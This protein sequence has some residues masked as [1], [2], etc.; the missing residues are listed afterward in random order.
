MRFQDA[1]DDARAVVYAGIQADPL[2]ARAADL[3]ADASPGS[4]PHRPGRDERRDERR[5]GVA[6]DVPRL[7]ADAADR[8]RRSRPIRGDPRACRWT[9]RAGA[10]R[11][12]AS[13]AARSSRR[14]RPGCW[15]VASCRPPSIASAGSC[16]MACAPRSTRTTSPSSCRSGPRGTT[17]SGARAGSAPD[18]LLQLDAARGH[19]E[20]EG[21]R[22]LVALVV[23]DARRSC[24]IRL[25]RQTAPL[26]GVRLVTIETL[27]A[28]GRAKVASTP[29]ERAP[30]NRPTATRATLP[31][32]V[33]RIHSGRAGAHVRAPAV[34]AGRRVGALG[35]A[36]LRPCLVRRARAR[37]ARPRSRARRFWPIPLGTSLEVTTSVA[38]HR[39]GLGP[40]ASASSASRAATDGGLVAWVHTDWLLIDARGR[41]TRVPAIFGTTFPAPLS[42][43]TLGRVAIPAPP[44]SAARQRF[45]VRPHELDPMDHVNNAVYVDWLEETVIAAGPDGARRP[46][47]GPAALPARGRGRR[48][49][50]W[51]SR[52]RHGATERGWAHR[53]A[54]DGTDVFRA[55]LDDL[56]CPGVLGC[57]GSPAAR[58]SPKSSAAQRRPGSGTIGLPGQDVHLSTPRRLQRHRWHGRTGC[59]CPRGPALVMLMWGGFYGSRARAVGVHRPRPLRPVRQSATVPARASASAR[60]GRLRT[61]DDSSI[62]QASDS[63]RQPPDAD[64]LTE[65]VEPPGPGGRV[66]TQAARGHR[67]A[68]QLRRRIPP[69]AA[70]HP[71]PHRRH[72]RSRRRSRSQRPRSRAH[73]HAAPSRPRP[74]HPPPCRPP[75]DQSGAADELGRTG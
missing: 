45:R 12:A 30:A 71:P 36:R 22:L 19:A 35:G 20:A 57:T 11:S 32:P 24:R 53:T 46:P 51:S 28:L 38:G 49:A 63:I 50:T 14:S 2:V 47:A 58:T 73:A 61:V 37:V 60:C 10:S 1:A 62:A 74:N 34:R 40:P 5:G 48:S 67:A 41:I 21:A 44:P 68:H 56:T 23:F 42:D 59:G 75:N 7:F 25:A 18:V 70:T 31:R 4:A 65:P 17:A 15:L 27:D 33:R 26:A 9:S 64:A 72:H 69:A 55:R 29:T 39:Q 3:L 13:S 8:R 16:S 52:R 66:Q 43:D 54:A 6:S